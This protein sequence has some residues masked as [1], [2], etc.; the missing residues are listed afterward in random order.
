MTIET[1]PNAALANNPA[2]MAAIVAAAGG[3]P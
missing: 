1:R 2:E 3:K